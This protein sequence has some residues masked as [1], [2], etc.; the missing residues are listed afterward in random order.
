M[1][2]LL[3]LH[4]G[5]S[6]L[7]AITSYISVGHLRFNMSIFLPLIIS[8][9][10]SELTSLGLSHLSK[11]HHPL[12]SLEDLL[13]FFAHIS[14]PFHLQILSTLPL[15]HILNRSNHIF[16]LINKIT[17]KVG[18]ISLPTLTIHSPHISS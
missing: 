16:Y 12:S 2:P 10:S 11:Q 18:V 9:F 14:H 8:T 6:C 1:R 4:I 5:I 3:K 13:L 15:K 17:S 7:L